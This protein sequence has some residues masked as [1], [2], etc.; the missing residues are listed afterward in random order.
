MK[1]CPTCNRLYRTGV[2]ICSD[3]GQVLK[4]LR[5]WRPDDE[6]LGRYRII[7]KM[8]HG[9][10]GPVYKAELLP[11][12]GIRIL[13]PLASQFAD[14]E[15][16]VD[17]FR[18]RVKAISQLRHQNIIYTEAFATSD[19]GRPFFVMEYFPG[20]PLR[21]LLLARPS[22]PA[23]SVAEMGRQVCSAL[24]AAHGFGIIHRNLKPENLLVMEEYDGAP[25]VKVMEFGFA[26]L[27]EA[28][29][30][31]GKLIGD[32]E[33]N[34]SV[35]VVG[36]REYMSPEQAAGTPA[37]IL[38]GR[39][40]IYSLGVILFEA[41]TRDLPGPA[42]DSALRLSQHPEAPHHKRLFAAVLKALQ[43]DPAFRFQSATAMAAVL[44]EAA[45]RSAS[46]ATVIASVAR[47][48]PVEQA[49][50]PE[51]KASRAAAGALNR[52]QMASDSRRVAPP[53]ADSPNGNGGGSSDLAFAE[54]RVGLSQPAPA[55]D[56]PPKTGNK[57]P[58]VRI[59][60]VALAI[61]VIAFL[62][63]Y[64][65]FGTP[66]ASE[67]KPASGRNQ[68]ASTRSLQGDSP[69]PNIGTSEHSARP[70][71]SEM[72]PPAPPTGGQEQSN[73][74]KNDP[75]QRRLDDSPWPT[76]QVTPS[77]SAPPP[78]A[79]SSVPQ[80]KANAEP[81]TAPEKS[82]NAVSEK[83]ALGWAA[84]E[85]KD[86]RSAIERFNEALKIDPSNVEAQ[87]A[88]RLA[89]YTYQHPDTEVLP[90]KPSTAS[91]GGL[92]KQP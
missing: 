20:M 83:L 90:S 9:T 38:D 54:I 49:G 7:E 23:A 21:E 30:E 34:A 74:L 56:V 71:D 45:G 82:E 32:V 29:A 77:I 46:T 33:Q 89:R 47:A 24:E 1:V 17:L 84:M 57:M 80:P 19:D 92:E 3:D 78:A 2:A 59:G 73:A 35:V 86:L 43:K 31:R 72:S 65:W 64:Q 67:P 48:S 28:A 61:G 39:S 85:R 11:Y 63:A 58:L 10:I 37:A 27:R 88:L 42:G 36:I 79:P 68:P 16:L 51:P 8:G 40:D 91:E 70:V 18:R 5:D 13:K 76:N 50:L 66:S 12:G 15:F 26:D 4:I 41:L 87:A 62:M 69:Q 81:I 22:L 14:D 25:T 6:V 52:D 75:T 55:S 60:G 44:T 53:Q